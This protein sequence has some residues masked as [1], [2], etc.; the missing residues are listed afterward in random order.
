[1]V[2]FLVVVLVNQDLS[3]RLGTSAHNLLVEFMR[4]HFPHDP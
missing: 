2:S 3:H 1:M 4:F